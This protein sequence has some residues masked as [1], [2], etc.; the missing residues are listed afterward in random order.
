MLRHPRLDTACATVAQRA[1]QHFVQAERIM[2]DSPRAAVRAPRLM[3]EAY[4][5]VLDGLM[6]R[7]WAAPRPR[8]STGKLRLLVAVLRYG[9]V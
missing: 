7:G 2:A 4:K 9:L 6:L 5:S 3:T 8:V 1:V